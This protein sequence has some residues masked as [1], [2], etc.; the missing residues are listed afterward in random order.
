MSERPAI[1]GRV[2]VRSN[3]VH[4][5]NAWHLVPGDVLYANRPEL[6]RAPNRPTSLQRAEHLYYVPCSVC[7]RPSYET[8][9]N[10]CTEC[11]NGPSPDEVTAAKAAHQRA[12][13]AV[14]RI[15]A[16]SEGGE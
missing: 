7:R 3:V 15:R 5:E 12:L 2:R 13:E 1:A 16:E 9:L 8:S 10:G 6:L 11:S 14:A 4:D